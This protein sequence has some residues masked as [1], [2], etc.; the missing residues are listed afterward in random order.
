MPTL[1]DLPALLEETACLA[2]AAGD[3]I[4]EIYAGDFAV[5]GKHDASPVTDADERAEAVILRGLRKL[6]PEVPLIAEEAASNGSIPETP[7]PW[8]WLID[9]LD[10]TREFAARN[11]EFT[12]NIALVHEGVPLLGVVL[13]P[14]T[15]TLFSGAAGCGSRV[16]EGGSQ[17]TICTRRPPAAGLTVVGSRSHADESAMRRH[18]N[19]LN[20]AGFRGV[21]SSLKFCL[22]A[23]GEADLYPR[24]GRTMEW[25][26]AAGQAVLA[27]AGGSVSRL[28]GSP[29]R[30]GKPGF[31]NPDF[32]ARGAT[33][34]S[35]FIA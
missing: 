14:A 18:L 5:R 22:I 27:A 11:G 7:G 32:I 13:A 9:P 16:D 23:R 8:F 29:L 3:L 6:T 24:F 31:E 21:G 10:G 25:D 34:S 12:V 35:P 20:V 28:D 15:G 4:M 33:E 30:Y 19:R 17:R 1:S 26:T 2:R